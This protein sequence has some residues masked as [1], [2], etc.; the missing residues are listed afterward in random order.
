MIDLHMICNAH[1][2]P[3]WQWEWEEGAAETLSTFRVAADFC[4]QY[5]GFVF[6]HNEALLYRWVEEYEPTLF[7]RI[8]KLVKQ[9]KWHVMGGWHLQPDCNMLSGESF[10]RQAADGLAYFKEKFDVR[11]TTA[12]NIDPFGHTRGL[13]Q[14]LHK[15]GFDS[16]L[17][18]RPSK[19][20]IDLPDDKELEAR[21]RADMER[22]RILE[23]MLA[24][25]W[26]ES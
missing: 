17:I 3:V 11:P 6:N 25:R 19:A 16:Y 20:W 2:D 13:V 21:R 15:C 14:I 8:Q 1:L 12:L 4:E 18:G 24:W 9:G 7:A 26:W 23:E 22:Q 10:I 5:D